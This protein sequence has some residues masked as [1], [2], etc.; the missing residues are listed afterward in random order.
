MR[1][2]HRRLAP[3][4]RAGDHYR[5]AASRKFSAQSRDSRLRGIGLREQQRR[6]ARAQQR[7]GTVAQFRAAESLGMQ[8]AGFLALER[9]LLRGAEPEP[10][11]HDVEMRG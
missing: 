2:Q 5:H 11:P 10:A 8:T 6:K 1:G 7:V 9:N 4:L 3:E